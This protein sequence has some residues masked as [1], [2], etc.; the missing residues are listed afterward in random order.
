M[1]TYRAKVKFVHRNSQTGKVRCFVEK[2][3]KFF[4]S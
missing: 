4:S 2:Q 1:K 3:A